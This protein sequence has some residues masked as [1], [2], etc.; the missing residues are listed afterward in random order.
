MAETSYF[1][2]NAGTGDSP[3]LGYGHTE[4]MTE[5][6]R[7]LLNGTDNQGVL[8]GWLL[9]LEPVDAGGLDVKVY[10]GGAI[11]YGFFYESDD[12]ETI[13]MPDDDTNHIVVRCSWAAQTVRLTTVAALVQTIG[14]TWDIPI[15]EVTTVGGDITV[16]TDER[17]FCEYSADMLHGIVTS[18]YITADAITTA[19][20][21]DETRWLCS[22]ALQPDETDT[23]SWQNVTH[24]SY[25]AT[26]HSGWAMVTGAER[27]VWWT[28][29]VPSDFS[30]TD[31][32]LYVRSVP[33]HLASPGFDVVWD[34]A[35][36]VAAPS[37]AFA[38]QSGSYVASQDG[39]SWGGGAYRDHIDTLT[40]AAGDLVRLRVARD[41]TDGL[42]T[43]THTVLLIAVE[44]EYVGDS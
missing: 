42:D 4:M 28:F 35:A 30:G 17:E 22:A 29:L 19:I 21:E 3:A 24:I 20:L 26:K 40:V 32:E 12:E 36:Q 14:V 44:V 38:A 31:L 10:R 16:L 39:R 1:W 13:T 11:V 7:M 18:D 41:G 43:E 37:A 6:F 25:G 5:V 33:L 2:D 23:P 27:A 34:W 9:E 15:A 8:K